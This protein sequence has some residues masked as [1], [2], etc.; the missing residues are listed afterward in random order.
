MTRSLGKELK[1]II[2]LFLIIKN[3]KFNLKPKKKIKHKKTQNKQTNKKH[4]NTKKRKHEQKQNASNRIKTHFKF[5][6]IKLKIKFQNNLL[7]LLLWRVIWLTDLKI[8]ICTMKKKCAS[9]LLIELK[10]RTLVCIAYFLA[11]NRYNYM[12]LFSTGVFYS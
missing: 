7:D 1:F 11:I 5:Y 8:K 10:I 2:K 9:H 6:S 12:Y 3:L 4:K